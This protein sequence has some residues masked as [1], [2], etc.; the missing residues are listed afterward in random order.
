MDD[1]ADIFKYIYIYN[2]PNVKSGVIP[3]LRN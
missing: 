1:T 3:Y 2:I